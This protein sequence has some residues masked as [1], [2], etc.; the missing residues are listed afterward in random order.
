MYSYIN[1]Q[2][3]CEN[4][5]ISELSNEIGS[6]FYCY[7][8]EI[9]TNKYSEIERAFEG[10]DLLICYSLKA[11]SNQS[12]IK[13]FSSMGSGA[14]VVSMGELKRAL[15]AGIPNDKIVFS[16]VGKSPEEI[17]F[18]LKN[19]ILMINVES[20]A[21]LNKI[22]ELA[23]SLNETAPIS[24]R[25]NP[26]I[27]AGEN[28]KIS[29]GKKQDKF[30]ISYQD[31]LEVYDLASSLNNIQIKGIDVHIGSQINN[32]EPFEQTFDCLIE[33]IE[34]L[35]N[36]DINIDIIDIGGGIG[37]NYTNEQPLEIKQYA[38]LIEE[39]LEPLNKKII[40]EPGRFLTAESGIL[41]TSVI[42]IKETSDKNFLI[43][44]AAMNDFIRPSLYG[45]MHKILPIKNHQIGKAE[46]VYD[47]V[48]PVCETG[49][50]FVKDYKTSQIEEDNLL[51][52]TYTGAYGSVLSS[53]YNSR[54]SIP[55]VLVKGKKFSI[56][57]NKEN[58]E[59][60]INQDS[61][62]EWL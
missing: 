53:N 16:G 57:K 40:I 8:S 38:K 41:V 6:P 61:I 14:D 27:S 58:I 35:K 44:D 47:V 5:D 15:K 32:I 54:P 52:I 17:N 30:G 25:I 22:S 20:V 43:V 60:I 11:N 9:L 26:D 2:L 29:T 42:Y 1:N 4:V 56:I 51:A 23:S 46:N 3:H 62:A 18:A 10:K 45:S 55:E 24:I 37:V 48:G 50:Y 7:S 59:E 13:T 19:N 49:D 34:N 33:V 28:E 36:K 39:K 12:I 31:I 21:E